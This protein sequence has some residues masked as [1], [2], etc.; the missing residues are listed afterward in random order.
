MVCDLLNAGIF[1]PLISKSVLEGC[2]IFEVSK[3]Y[4][5]FLKKVIQK[6][7]FGELLAVNVIQ[8]FEFHSGQD[9]MTARQSRTRNVQSDF[10]QSS[11]LSS[12]R[13]EFFASKSSVTRTKPYTLPLLDLDLEVHR[14]QSV[15]TSPGTQFQDIV[16]SSKWIVCGNHIHHIQWPVEIYEIGSRNKRVISEQKNTK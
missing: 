1:F 9:N 7:A 5:F 10:G 15:I 4:H 12:K 13:F 2:I 11:S 6:H 8:R 3:K 16:P 14:T